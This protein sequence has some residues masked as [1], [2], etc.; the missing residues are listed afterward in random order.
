MFPNGGI[1]QDENKNGPGKN[2][3]SCLTF[4]EHQ[5]RV[6][7]LTIVITVV[8]MTPMVRLKRKITIVII[9]TAVTVVRF[10]CGWK[11]GLGS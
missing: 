1:Y 6:N 5:R 7:T 8:T 2:D 3:E 9:L 10:F 11:Q 4:L